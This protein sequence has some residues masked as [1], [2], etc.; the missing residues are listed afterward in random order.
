MEIYSRF[1]CRQTGYSE[2]LTEEYIFSTR[3][4]SS[5]TRSVIHLSLLKK[6][7]NFSQNDS[8]ISKNKGGK[9]IFSA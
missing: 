4:L 5:S 3:R 7:Q 9:N 6:E 8:D 1:L 2:V